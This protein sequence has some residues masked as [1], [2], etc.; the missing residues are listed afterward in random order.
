MAMPGMKRFVTYIYSYENK[1]KGNNTG[2]AR[3]EVRGA[4]GRIEIHLRG[5]L[6]RTACKVYLFRLDGKNMEG[7]YIGEFRIMNGS[8]DFAAVFQAEQIA[9]SPFGFSDLDGVVIFGEDRRM[10]MSRWTEGEEFTVSGENFHLW[11]QRRDAAE[12][13]SITNERKE[14]DKTDGL[15]NAH[16]KTVVGSVAGQS[17]LQNQTGEKD[18]DEPVFADRGS[19]ANYTKTETLVKTVVTESRTLPQQGAVQQD[20]GQNAPQSMGATIARE[21]SEQEDVAA[22]EI[23]MQNIFPNYTW[24]EIWE[25]MGSD[26]DIYTPFE[27]NEIQCMRIELKNLRQ[28]PKQYWY[29]GNNSFLL[30][31]FFNYHYLLLGREGE[32]FFVGIPGIFQRQEHVMAIIFGF[33]EFLPSA[34]ETGIKPDNEGE[35]FEPLN[36]FGFWIHWIDA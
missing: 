9:S 33:P 25:S 3:L 26:H 22:T 29:L 32:R 24:Q 21:H 14:R 5:I 4:D 35:S 2:F 1:V 15:E 19:G 34:L 6:G 31:G 30:H 18:A 17:G 11:E 20:P 7:F 10:F 16:Q 36:R 13:S 28:L 23:P 12:E 8:G 27:D